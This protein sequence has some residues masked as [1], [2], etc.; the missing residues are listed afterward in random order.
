MALSSFLK[1][2]LAGPAHPGAP[3]SELDSCWW[4]GEHA[5]QM[6]GDWGTGIMYSSCSAWSRALRYSPCPG[7]TSFHVHCW[8][9]LTCL[10]SVVPFLHPY[11]GGFLV[12]PSILDSDC[13]SSLCNVSL[14]FIQVR[15][16]TPSCKEPDLFWWLPFKSVI[17]P[18]FF[19]NEQSS[20]E[21]ITSPSKDCGFARFFFNP[22]FA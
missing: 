21:V 4:L 10:S 17:Q 16:P 3:V 1:D 8:R 14:S 12:L 6:Q 5:W 9:A 18:S 2:G 19:S 13:V 7:A 20:C 11:R 22:A 15:V